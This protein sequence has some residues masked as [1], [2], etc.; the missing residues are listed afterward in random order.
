MPFLLQRP[1]QCPGN[2]PL[3]CPEAIAA[4]DV[5]TMTVNYRNE[6]VALRVHNPTTNGQAD[7][8]AGDLSK[9]YLSNVTRADA[10]LNTQPTFYPPLT[11]DVQ[12]RDPFTPLLRAYEDDHVQVRILVGAQEEGHNFAVHGVKWYF[13]PGTPGQTTPN[14]SG[15]RNSQ[16]MGISEHF[17]FDAPESPDYVNRGQARI[18]HPRHAL[19]ARP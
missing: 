11:A 4:D 5:G 19:S 3:P 7:S 17:E 15:F 12:P 16:I 13:E 18:H 10:R 6:P 1:Q 14:N 8:A 9:V 2:V